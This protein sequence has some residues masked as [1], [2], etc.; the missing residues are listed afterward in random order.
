MKKIILT[1]GLCA[2]AASPAAAEKIKYYQD[3]VYQQLI[4]GDPHP[5]SDLLG[6]AEEND[7]RAQFILGD[8]YAKG[9]GGLSKNEKKAAYWFEQ[10]AKRGYAPSFVR[11]A[12]LSK[13][14]GDKV[15]AYK[16]YTL[17][18]ESFR[19]GADRK[20]AEKARTALGIG[21]A[22][23]KQAKK[24]ADAWKVMKVKEDQE[25][26]RKKKTDKEDAFLEKP[27]KAKKERYANE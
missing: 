7:V 26:K 3:P 25:I 22:E 17:A 23:A 12:A 4:K 2:I 24:A 18:T 9:K 13:R 11:L 15:E 21:N 19:S 27:A 14:R 20:Y 6:L 16:W 1:I 10:S 8:L 5:M